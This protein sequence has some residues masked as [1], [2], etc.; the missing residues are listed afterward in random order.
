MHGA[1][2]DRSS[3]PPARE[4]LHCSNAA[5]CSTLNKHELTPT[6]TTPSSPTLLFDLNIFSLAFDNMV[7]RADIGGTNGVKGQSAHP[8]R[9]WWVNSN[10][11]E[12]VRLERYK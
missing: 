6:A 1:L 7:M 2:V 5:K 12:L 4:R 10:C 9:P 8:P 3:P 11:A